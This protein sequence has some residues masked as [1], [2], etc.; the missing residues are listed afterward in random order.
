MF[1]CLFAFPST[2]ALASTYTVAKGDSLYQIS[3]RYK[4]P[5]EEI[6]AANNLKDD[7]ISPGQQLNIPDRP[8]TVQEGD[9]LY[10]IGLRFGVSFQEIMLANGLKNEDI[11]PGQALRIPAGQEN[12][13]R[14][15]LSPYGR[16]PYS[17]GDLDLLAR[18]I[19]AEAD[20]ES[21]VAKVAVGA[22]VLNRVKSPLFPNTIAK[23]I[24]QANGGVY[25]FVPVKNGSI[26]RPAKPDSIQAAK[27]ALNGSDPSGGALYFF[28]TRVSSPFLQSLPV[29]VKLDSFTFAHAK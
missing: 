13:S 9:N 14:G 10:S 6:R 26:N 28:E 19:T 21:Y 7:V 15:D 12:V 24:N 3:Q 8:Y 27:E 5:V 20:S 2:F 22:V 29:S 18:L 17:E 16:I 1:L 4:T 11:Y 25:Q 23:V